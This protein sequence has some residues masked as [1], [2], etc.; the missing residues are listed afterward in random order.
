MLHM[1]PNSIV[2]GCLIDRGLGIDSTHA[3]IAQKYRSARVR[4]SRRDTN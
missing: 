2:S 1:L 3:G 4:A